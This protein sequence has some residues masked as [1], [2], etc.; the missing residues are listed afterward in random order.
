MKKKFYN[1]LFAAI[2]IILIIPGCRETLNEST[3]TNIIIPN[4]EPIENIIVSSP[5]DGDIYH[6][7]GSV[8]I[9]WLS[10]STL[11]KVDIFLFRKSELKRTITLNYENNGIYRWHI[12]DNIDYST[13]YKIKVLNS[14]S[15]IDYNFS[16]RFEIL[17]RDNIKIKP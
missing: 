4:Y 14:S 3:G 10:D 7:G 6:P 13:R 11:S 2:V 15:S 8:T 16:G 5:E 1:S 9:K 17:K 12:P